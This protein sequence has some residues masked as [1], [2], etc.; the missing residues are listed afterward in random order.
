MTLGCGKTFHPN[1]P[2]N[3]DEPHSCAATLDPFSC[4]FL[5]PSDTPPRAGCRVAGDA[6]LPTHR[7]EMQRPQ[8]PRHVARRRNR[9][10]QVRQ[11]LRCRRAVSRT[12]IFRL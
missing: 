6:V 2:P 11:V 4:L 9:H 12:N 5:L 10:A 8:G 1:L 7:P 3:F